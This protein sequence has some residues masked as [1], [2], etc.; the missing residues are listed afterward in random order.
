MVE[1]GPSEFLALVNGER[2]QL[3]VRELELRSGARRFEAS[4]MNPA[5]AAGFA[6]GAVIRGET[7]HFEIVSNESAS[8]IT[9]VQLDT[10]I[11]I[12]IVTT[13]CSESAIT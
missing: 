11:P 3:T 10:G 12:V 7:Y 5:L 2:L 1:V 4:T 13:F 9:S 6:L 8:G